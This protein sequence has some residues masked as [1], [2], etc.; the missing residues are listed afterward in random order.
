MEVKLKYWDHTCG[1]GCCSTEGVD[2]YIDGKRV[3]QGDNENIE[4]ILTDV[5]KHLGYDVKIETEYEE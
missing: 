5:L 1:D 4:I 3:S 2:V